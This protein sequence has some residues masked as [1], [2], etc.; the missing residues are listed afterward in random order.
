M[1]QQD[2]QLI[3]SGSDSL[4]AAL[5]GRLLLNITAQGNMKIPLDKGITTI[6]RR[7]ANDLCINSR[8]I[9]RFHARIINTAAGAIIEDL[10]IG[11]S[12]DLT[13]SRLATAGG[14]AH[15]I[16]I[17]YELVQRHKKRAATK[18]RIVP[19]AKF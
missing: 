1:N 7:T 2:T 16:T 8:Y 11:Y 9:S 12:Y 4:R 6:G 15:E 3:Y 19:C 13:I 10:R 17:G 18:R 5:P 14:G